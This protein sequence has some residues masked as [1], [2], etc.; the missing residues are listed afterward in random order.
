M[1]RFYW[2]VKQ[3]RYYI[4][5]ATTYPKMFIR[6]NAVLYACAYIW[7]SNIVF[8]DFDVFWWL[9]LNTKLCQN[10]NLKIKF[11]YSFIYFVIYTSPVNNINVRLIITD[12][13]SS[14]SRFRIEYTKSITSKK[15]WSLRW[16]SGSRLCVGHCFERSSLTFILCIILNL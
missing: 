3:T 11:Y 12:R 4:Y 10:S 1:N 2:N 16:R 14:G 15:V 13:L 6:Y 5:N 7:N 8:D 9:N